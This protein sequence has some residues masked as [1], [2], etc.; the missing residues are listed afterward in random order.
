MSQR[1]KLFCLKMKFIET[2]HEGQLN[3][4]DNWADMTLLDLL[5]LKSSMIYL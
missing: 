3:L 1:G 4:F 2:V 5:L